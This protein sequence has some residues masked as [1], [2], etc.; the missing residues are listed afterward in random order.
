MIINLPKD[1]EKETTHRYG[2][3]SFKLHRWEGGRRRQCGGLCVC[4]CVHWTGGA[5]SP[6][7]LLN[8]AAEA[9]AEEEGPWAVWQS[10]IAGA[11][12]GRGQSGARTMRRV[13]CLHMTAPCRCSEPA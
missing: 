4:V 11:E 12:A 9:E 10:S 5:G 3:N 8:A 13:P 2:P 6:A 1:L 7:V